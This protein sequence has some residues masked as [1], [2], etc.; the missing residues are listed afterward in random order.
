M[1]VGRSFGDDEGNEA[2]VPYSTL[3][4]LLLQVTESM[5]LAR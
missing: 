4:A 2:I 1:N 3:P 5:S